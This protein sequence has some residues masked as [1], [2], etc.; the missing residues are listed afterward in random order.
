MVLAGLGLKT[1]KS[2]ISVWHSFNQTLIKSNVYWFQELWVSFHPQTLRASLFSSE[3]GWTVRIP[4]VE[5]IDII[6][7]AHCSF[8]KFWV[9]QPPYKITQWH[10]SS[11]F[12]KSFVAGVWDSYTVAF[13]TQPL[14]FSNYDF[15]EAF[16]ESYFFFSRRENSL[17]FQR[18]LI[19][20]KKKKPKSIS[21][22]C[23]I[24]RNFSLT[25]NLPSVCSAFM[26]F[27]MPHLENADSILKWS[28]VAN[29]RVPRSHVICSF[30][31]WDCGAQTLWDIWSYSP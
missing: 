3:K 7:N 14:F 22:K 5:N 6:S 25:V 10:N 24:A 16:V 21:S 18:K 15:G 9:R 13:A 8:M 12:R 28:F 26:L 27:I 19:M 2:T 29:K 11:Y 1:K 31:L 4:S 17:I 20:K 30:V 23:M